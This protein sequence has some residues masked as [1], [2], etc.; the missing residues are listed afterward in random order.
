MKGKAEGRVFLQ[1]IQKGSITMF[2]A[3]AKD[4]FEISHGL[5]V[6]YGEKQVDFFHYRVSPFHLDLPEG[7]F[8]ILV[9]ND[10]RKVP[11]ARVAFHFEAFFLNLKEKIY[12]LPGL[13]LQRR[14]RNG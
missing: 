3:F 14:K 1:G 8:K 12:S 13:K 2:P 11:A 10:Q 6:V 7:R 4:V 9:R 5:M